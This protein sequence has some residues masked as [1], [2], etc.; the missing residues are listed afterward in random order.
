MRGNFI[1]ILLCAAHHTL[2]LCCAACLWCSRQSTRR[3]TRSHNNAR[4]GLCEPALKDSAAAD[5]G[6]IEDLRVLRASLVGFDIAVLR[7]RVLG[8]QERAIAE[9]FFPRSVP[10][11]RQWGR[12]HGVAARHQ[13]IHHV[14]KALVRH[15]IGQV[16]AVH[17]GVFHPALQDI[18]HGA[19]RAEKTPGPRPPM[20]AHRAKL[21]DGRYLSP[22]RECSTTDRWC[23]FPPDGHTRRRTRQSRCRPAR[24]TGPVRHRAT[25]SAGIPRTW[26]APWL[27]FI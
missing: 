22:V 16:E 27:G 1:R 15:R 20:P 26:P 4:P 24:Q 19:G 9:E 8:R 14:F 2:R 23:W 11:R 10:S 3:T 25:H 13:V 18:G 21:V 17:V 12:R 7:R 6:R 5:G